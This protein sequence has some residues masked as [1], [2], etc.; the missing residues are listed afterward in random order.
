MHGGIKFKELPEILT[1][2]EGFLMQ[3]GKAYVM[4]ARSAMERVWK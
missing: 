1:R 2:K 3:K 4:C